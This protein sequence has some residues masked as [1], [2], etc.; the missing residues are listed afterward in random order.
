MDLDDIQRRQAEFF[1]KVKGAINDVNGYVG[2]RFVR[3]A[4][5]TNTY[6]D[7]TANLR[8]S[9]GYG[10]YDDA[11]TEKAN[12]PDDKT[13]KGIQ[14]ADEAAAGTKGITVVLGAGMEYAAAVEARGYDV[15]SNSV[16][17]AKQEHK[18]LIVAALKGIVK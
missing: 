15:V 1:S 16:N 12:F 4:R 5:K 9:I 3:N 10:E 13:R 17:V 14:M 11:K 2:E 18:R 8:N 7:R 6:M